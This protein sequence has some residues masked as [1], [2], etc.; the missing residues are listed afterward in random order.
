Q[1]LAVGRATLGH[2]GV[3]DGGEL[4]SSLRAVLADWTSWL[5]SARGPALVMGWCLR[6]VWPVSLARGGSPVKALN[7]PPLGNR[8]G[9][10]MVATSWVVPT[11]PSPG[12][13]A[14]SPAGSTPG[15]GGVPGVLVAGGRG[16]A[17]ADQPDLAGDL[18]GQ[19]VQ[20]GRGV[21][22]PPR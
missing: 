1:R 10:P 14:A 22:L 16:L 4:G 17:G 20:G 18:R 5:R 15:H 3:V 8:P 21:A 13:L 7:A 19:G 12:R 9:R 2:L 11:G 6:S